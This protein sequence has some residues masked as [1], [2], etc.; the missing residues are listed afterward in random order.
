[1]LVD[2]P[3]ERRKIDGNRI[4]FTNLSKSDAQVLQCNAS[5]KHGYIFKNVYLNVLAEPPSFIKPPLPVVKVAEGQNVNLTC[6]VFGAPK[7]VITWSKG[8]EKV[9]GSR[10]QILKTGDLQILVSCVED[11]HILLTCSVELFLKC[12]SFV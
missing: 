10:F 5:N 4:L 3:N 11:L 12:C 9:T 7:P 1:M 8:D 2:F 6:R